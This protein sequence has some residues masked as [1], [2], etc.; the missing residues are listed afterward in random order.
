MNDELLQLETELAA[1]RPARM[2]SRLLARID[3]G[4]AALPDATTAKLVPFPIEPRRVAARPTARAGWWAAAAA[5]ALLGSVAAL[6][7]PSRSTPATDDPL[8]VVPSVTSHFV[9][10]DTRAGVREVADQGIVRTNEQQAFRRVRVVYLEHV[11]LVN[12][13]GEKIVIEQPRVEYL[14][15][16]EEPR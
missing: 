11:T 10:A 2:P 3:A 15:V 13:R 5:V 9:P 6:M 7:A 4:V 16:P 1:L 14:L 12:E 8:V